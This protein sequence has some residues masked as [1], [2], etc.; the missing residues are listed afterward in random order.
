MKFYA[1]HDDPHGVLLADER[2][3]MHVWADD[4]AG[5]RAVYLRHYEGDKPDDPEADLS[6]EEATPPD[7]G[8]ALPRPHAEERDG[9]LRRYHY[10]YEGDG[11]CD[12]CGLY[13][14]D[15]RFPVCEECGQCP[16]CAACFQDC[17]ECSE[18]QPDEVVEAPTP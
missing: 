9:V 14:M 6:C 2:T 5:A 11:S 16:E 10:R 18:I 12:T 4:P 15:G 1:V 13:E 7:E 3:H 8:P 17:P